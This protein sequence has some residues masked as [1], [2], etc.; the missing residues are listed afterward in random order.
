MYQIQGL[1]TNEIEVKNEELRTSDATETKPKSKSKL[2]IVSTAK[3]NLPIPTSNIA[4]IFKDEAFTFLQTFDGQQYMMNYT[5]EE[6]MLLLDDADFFRANRQII[7]SL[8]S[9]ASFTNEENGKISL[10]LLPKYKGDTFISQ[11]KASEFRQ[12]LHR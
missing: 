6:L 7:I 2:I 11:K 8:K 10:E 9:C 1:K 12:W 3:K 4:Y 5:L